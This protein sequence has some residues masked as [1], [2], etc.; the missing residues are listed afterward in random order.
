MRNERKALSVTVQATDNFP[1]APSEEAVND[2]NFRFFFCGFYQL[3]VINYNH[4]RCKDEELHR[5][6]QEIFEERPL[7]TRIAIVR[8]TGLDEPTLR[9]H[10]AYCFVF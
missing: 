5:L 3:Y 1:C 4:S 6:L 9:F 10:P 7:W 2:A 8:K